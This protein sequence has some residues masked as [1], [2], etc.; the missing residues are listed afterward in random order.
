[1]S[2]RWRIPSAWV[3]ALALALC[4]GG[5]AGAVS[6][7]QFARQSFGT[8]AED[9]RTV[10]WSSGTSRR[11][12]VVMDLAEEYKTRLLL[13]VPAKNTFKV[14][15]DTKVDTIVRDAKLTD[16]DHDGSPE[17]YWRTDTSG[18]AFGTEEFF[19][20]DV[21][22]K[23][24]Y[25]AQIDYDT[26]GTP[27]D[28]SFGPAEKM[29]RGRLMRTFLTAQVRL[30]PHMKDTRS[31]IT[32]LAHRWM[33]EYGGGTVPSKLDQRIEARLDSAAC[34]FD[35]QDLARAVKVGRFQ[36]V[37]LHAGVVELD[38]ARDG[39]KLKLTLEFS[40]DGVFLFDPVTRTFTFP[41]ASREKREP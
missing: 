21:R 10:W 36:Y 1:M 22:S 34:R 3:K 16:V 18:S 14:T 24:T 9:V 6:P 39:E 4:L 30:S 20:R 40:P 29:G 35:Q 38:R 27:G 33:E 19:L 2:K 8:T 7:E 17:V 25:H 15:W 13:L 31:A 12:L 11:A 26:D 5:V 23:T 32:K 37:G 41:A 28:A